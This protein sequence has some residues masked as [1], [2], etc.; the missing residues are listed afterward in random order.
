MLTTKVEQ[1]CEKYEDDNSLTLYIEFV[2]CCVECVELLGNKLNQ[3][4]K[5]VL[6]QVKTAWSCPYD[7]ATIEGLRRKFANSYGEEGNSSERNYAMEAANCTLM[8]YEMWEP[9]EYERP[10]LLKYCVFYLQNADVP[11]EQ[12]YPIIKK[13]FPDLD[14]EQFPPQESV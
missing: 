2:R 14:S 12:M 1:L 7:Q 5:Q 4:E 10:N 8:L 9:E 3:D 11:D 6:Q 13:H